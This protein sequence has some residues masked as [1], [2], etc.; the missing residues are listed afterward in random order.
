M[1]QPRNRRIGARGRCSA[2][3]PKRK[4][5]DVMGRCTSGR[6]IGDDLPDHGGE[7]EAVTGAGRSDNDVG[8]AGQS[9][10][11]EVAVGVMV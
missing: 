3:A 6:E 5:R 8:G 9:I 4:P 7:F 10:D 1:S 11:E 2:K